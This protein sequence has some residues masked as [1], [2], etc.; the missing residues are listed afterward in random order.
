[1]M[2]KHGEIGFA[3]ADLSLG[4]LCK[5][6]VFSMSEG[7]GVWTMVMGSAKRS[8]VDIDDSG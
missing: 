6:R 7:D 4:M 1:M 2:V 8:D 5:P 3:E